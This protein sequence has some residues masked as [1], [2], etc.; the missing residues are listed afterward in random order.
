[1]KPSYYRGSR[2]IVDLDAI[3]SNIKKEM[4]KLDKNKE[5]FAVVKANAY[6]HGATVVAKSAIQAG[7]T[8]LCVSNLDEALELREADVSEPI[9]VLSYVSLEYVNLAIK[10][11]ITLTATN[12]EWLIGLDEKIQKPIKIHLKIDT[13]MGRV[14]LRDDNEMQIAKNLLEKSKYI[15]FEGLFTHFAKADSTDNSY[16]ELQQQRFN[17]AVAIFGHEIK[18][19]H[20]S[21]S[22]TALWHEAWK[23]NLVR[24]GVATYGMNPSGHELKDPYQLKQAL[25]L[26]TEIIHIKQLE[27]GEKIGYGATYET[28]E[29]EWIATL[30]IGYADGFSR[31]FQGYEVIISGHK[32]PVVGRICMDQCMVKLDRELPIGT[33]VT[34]FGGNQGVFNSVQSGAEY[35]QTIN[36][37]VT[38]A[39]TDRLPRVYIKNGQ[40]VE[41]N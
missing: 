38:C 3:E 24:Y 17:Q 10:N 35:I 11:N 22:A 4:K 27:K 32:Y 19:I 36:Y 5:V 13:G 8:G 34:I 26:E 41:F 6:G 23:S 20:T 12:L 39:L 25:T 28:Q 2:V 14:G 33:K 16:L 7:A 18:Y 1:M 31:G 21:N 30:P 40:E 15:D 9:I 37:E 29:K